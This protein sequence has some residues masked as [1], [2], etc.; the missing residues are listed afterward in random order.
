MGPGR[1][2]Q[3][4][5]VVRDAT[6]DWQA[7]GYKNDFVATRQ[8]EEEAARKARAA[9][10]AAGRIG[11]QPRSSNDSGS[12]DDNDDDSDN[13]PRDDQ[14][15][16]EPNSPGLNP[17]EDSTHS[18]SEESTDEVYRPEVVYND[19]ERVL[20]NADG[21]IEFRD[22]FN[23]EDVFYAESGNP[24]Q[25][26]DSGAV[27]DEDIAVQDAKDVEA[28]EDATPRPDSAIGA[29][30]DPMVISSDSSVVEDSDS[31]YDQITN[32]PYDEDNKF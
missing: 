32:V 5:N 23:D 11:K 24:V 1:H 21:T 19:G 22:P 8:E 14:S 17:D 16:E 9:A 3:V 6:N 2:N 28:Q 18:E 12:S 31:S 4:P 29:E 20:Y 26:T 10:R 15:P 30:D 13:S 25:Y 27:L 7:R